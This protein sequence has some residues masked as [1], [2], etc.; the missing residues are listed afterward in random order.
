ME[1]GCNY[2]DSE[3]LTIHEA[4]LEILKRVGVQVDSPQALE[5]LSGAGVRVNPQTRRV[6]P[7]A[8]HIEKAL[9]SV[10]RCMTVYGRNAEHD[11]P[12][13]MSGRHVNLMAGGG[14]LRVLDLD[15]NYV[16]ATWEHLRQFNILLDALPNIHMCVNQ[17]D[18]VDQTGANFYCRLAA[19]MLIHCAKPIYMQLATSDDVRAMIEMGA[20]VRGSH[21]AHVARPLFLFAFNATPPLRISQNI[22]DAFIAACAA[23]L[24]VSMGSYSLMGV[25]APRT[26]AGAA[27][28]LEAVQMVSIVLAQ[29]VRPGA[30]I[31]YTAFSGSA[32]LHTLGECT[33]TPHATQLVRL[34]T[35][36][37]RFHGLP[38][39][40]VAE[41]DAREPDA[42]LA[43][44]RVLQLQTAIEAGGH[45][46]QGPAWADHMMLSSFALAVLDNDIIGL[47][48]ESNRRPPINAETLALE[49]IEEVATDSEYAQLRY[50]SHE[51]TVRHLREGVWEPMTFDYGSFENWC[52]AGK[53]SVGARANAKAREILATHR[54]EPLAS[55]KA[56][57]IR[58]IGCSA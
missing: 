8:Q 45:L 43:S 17:V 42:Q 18:P 47:V 12:V 24:P 19:E 40:G 13:I 50:A 58:R 51:H 48:L 11:R 26:V 28:E 33:A 39:Y 31:C 37:G 35:Q 3:L 30:P 27:V 34:T 1:T 23:G 20:V 7:E 56:D 57:V 36:M 14:A 52:K 15:G 4:S 38:V 6:H 9:A 54:P 2:S 44:E 5:I 21:D 32:D 10:P 29:A 49:V 25:T 22:A 16:A 46:M 55:D 41:S 53:P